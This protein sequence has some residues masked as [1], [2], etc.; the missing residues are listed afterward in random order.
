MT[1]QDL[2][3]LFDVQGMT[4]EEEAYLA[5]QQAIA[6]QIAAEH[7]AYVYQTPPQQISPPSFEGGA[8]LAQGRPQAVINPQY[9]VPVTAADPYAQYTSGANNVAMQAAEAARL[10]Q[11]AS[12]PPETFNY[13]TELQNY[14]TQNYGDLPTMG[15]PA[16]GAFATS[17]K[18]GGSGQYFSDSG[19]YGSSIAPAGWD[20]SQT[21]VITGGL[22]GLTPEMRQAGIER[23]NQP[24]I[25]GTFLNN[26][27]NM[28]LLSYPLGSAGLQGP[29]TGTVTLGEAAGTAYDA[30]M[31]D[32]PVVSPFLREEVVPRAGD[33]GAFFGE[34]LY[35]SGFGLADLL[36]IGPGLR[37]EAGDVG[38]FAGEAVVPVTAGDVALELI[39]GIGTIPDLARIAPDIA[40]QAARGLDAASLRA[41]GD[42]VVT[43]YHIPSSDEG[44]ESILRNGL[45]PGTAVTT[46]RELAEAIAERWGFEPL[47]FKARASSLVDDAYY[48]RT[49]TPLRVGDTGTEGGLRELVS[50]EAAVSRGGN[51][52]DPRTYLPERAVPP[53]EFPEVPWTMGGGSQHM[54]GVAAEV[55]GAKGPW[56]PVADSTV[57]DR[58][59]VRTA[60]NLINEAPVS[61]RPLYHGTAR[62][63]QYAD[64][65]VGDEVEVPLMAVTQNRALAS[66]Y[67]TPGNLRSQAGFQL[68]GNEAVVWRVQDAPA[69]TVR[70]NEQVI[71]GRFEVVNITKG[72]AVPGSEGLRRTADGTLEMAPPL[73]Q[74]VVTLRYKDPLPVKADEAIETVYDAPPPVEP[75]PPPTGTPDA[76]EPA[77][78]GNR[79]AAPLRDFE[80]VRDE[81][82][83]TENPIVRA[84]IAKTGINPSVADGSDVGKALTAYLRQRVASEE[85]TQTA[86]TAALDPHAQRFTGR[87]G[88]ILPINDDGLMTVSRGGIEGSTPWQDVFSTPDAFDLTPA[89]RAYIADYQQVVDDVEFLRVASGLRPLAKT[90]PEGWHYVPRQVENIRGIDLRRPSNAHLQRVYE[91][92]I[93]GY[94]RGVRYD[95]DPRATLELHVRAAYKE[96]AEKQLSDAIEPISLTAKELV[97]APVVKRLEDAI[98]NRKSV[99]RTVRKELETAR[100]NLARPADT[101][102]QVA[103]RKKDLATLEDLRAK[104]GPR[105]AEAQR[106]YQVAKNAYTKALESS[107]AREIAPGAFWGREG[108]IPVAQWRNRFMPREDADR[109]NEII[110]RFTRKGEVNPV[111]ATYKAIETVGNMTRFLSAVGDFGQPFIQGL[112]VLATNP[113]AWAKS[114]ALHY[115]AWFDPTVQSRF[116]RNHL[117]TFQEMAQNGV[118]IGDPEF[119][120]ALREGEGISFGKLI[121]GLPKGAQIRKMGQAVGKQTFGRFGNQYA[122]GLGSS[123]A[124]LWEASQHLEPQARAQWIRNLTGGLDSRALGTGPN[125]RAVEGSWMAFSPR[126]FRSTSALVADAMRPNTP[127]GRAALKSLTQ[128]AGGA[129]GLYVL[130]GLAMGKD[131]E[132]IET[133]LNPLNGKKFLSH[134]VNGDWI[135]IGGQVRAI[136][137]LIGESASAVASGDVDKFWSMNQFDNPLVNFYLNRGA[138]LINMSRSLIEGVSGGAL[139]ANPFAQIDNL[140]DMLKHIGTSALPF[141]VQAAVE[142]Q[143][144]ISVAAGFLGLRT[145][146]ETLTEERNRKL[147][148]AIEATGLDFIKDKD[149]ADMTTA[150]RTALREHIGE[151]LYM[152]LE[153]Q[154]VD[155][156]SIFA[157]KRQEIRDFYNSPEIK[158][159]TDAMLANLSQ[160]G[161]H[162]LTKQA[163]DKLKE[164]IS[165]MYDTDLEYQRAVDELPS[166]DIDKLID[167]YY[168]LDPGKRE[169]F[170]LGL[171]EL[172]KKGTVDPGT[173]ERVRFNTTPY[174]NPDEPEILRLYD[175]FEASDL[176]QQYDALPLGKARLDFR[177]AHPEFDAQMKA[178]GYVK[179]DE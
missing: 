95:S 38:R 73:R 146:P 23:E 114:A 17:S 160:G 100:K 167:V 121:Q 77:S 55:T 166:R 135:G 43:V 115:T 51:P 4:P 70:P 84:L 122:T 136:A 97:P 158:A 151:D 157:K 138:P 155:R 61:T 8:G 126:L 49:T 119:F 116:I 1:M 169:A 68:T 139:N 124:L 88:N 60:L 94:A 179:G 133:G 152:D 72:P 132:D 65:K 159:R 96:M 111:T 83:T 130:S 31:T 30:Y 101:P 74:K 33:A 14:A 28:P 177:A 143:N 147:P 85:L 13:G 163:V 11:M 144:A 102:R 82:V 76:P 46:D 128:L 19:G 86:V 117:D 137:Q 42:Q 91:D 108:E 57:E 18:I 92:A 104:A 142:G 2:L 27:A 141:S 69:Y 105:I 175:R 127:Q 148:D 15:P 170:I 123:R 29:Q 145:S 10:Q 109:M 93:D 25:L 89:Q 66:Q 44:L 59:M 9:D 134:E 12:A 99:E 79:Y 120:A 32:I 26:V 103:L 149:W 106:Q 40:R 80:S 6:A 20:E 131:W 165:A 50:G 54:T 110:G 112:P 36:G 98:S 3:A 7:D 34:E 5:E 64:W 171:A 176:K 118:P 178:L 52:L 35:R 63:S 161:D 153:K 58:D 107:R 53:S 56:Y 75:P 37:E 154:A 78:I 22:L 129:T 24:G 174:E 162:R 67:A 47:E 16:G 150:E 21:G 90:G 156:G 140:P 87:L 168:A 45:N 39:P 71:S 164:Q 41:L 48:Q 125:Q 113:V 81:V 172:E 62:A 173:A